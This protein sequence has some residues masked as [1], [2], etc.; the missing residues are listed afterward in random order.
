MASLLAVFHPVPP[1]V[2]RRV[3][4]LLDAIRAAMK[5]AL[6]N[7]NIMKATTVVAETAAPTSGNETKMEVDLEAVVPVVTT[8]PSELWSTGTGSRNCSV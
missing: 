4:E 8:T 1:V 5:D 7:A 2:R 3:K 6:G